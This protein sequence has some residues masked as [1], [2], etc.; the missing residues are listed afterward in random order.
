MFLFERLLS[1]IFGGTFGSTLHVLLTINV[2]AI[3]RLTHDRNF[4]D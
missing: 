2:A 3:D 4:M 1:S